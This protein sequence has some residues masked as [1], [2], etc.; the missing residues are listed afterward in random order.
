MSRYILIR[1]YSQRETC[2]KFMETRYSILLILCS[3][4]LYIK[5]R[6]IKNKKVFILL[7]NSG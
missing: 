7:L 5:E 4:Y 3:G 1:G 6:D 2:K